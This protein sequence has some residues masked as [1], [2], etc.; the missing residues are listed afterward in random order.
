MQRALTVLLYAIGC[1]LVLFAGL[2][3]VIVLWHALGN[4]LETLQYGQ[5]SDSNA[6]YCVHAEEL[7]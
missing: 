5:D 1:V 3:L 6:S 4:L 2:F 7:L